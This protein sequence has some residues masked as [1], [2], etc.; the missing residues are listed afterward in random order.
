M[1]FPSLSWDR[2]RSGF[3]SYRK[4]IRLFAL[5]FLLGLSGYIYFLDV[6]IREA[7]EGRKFAV[8]ARVY[9]RALEVYP[10]L[11]LTSAQFADELRRDGYHENPEPNA[12]ATYKYTLNGLEFTTRDFVFGDGPQAHGGLR[13]AGH[14]A[15]GYYA[16]AG[17]GAAA[18]VA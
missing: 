10:G 17:G 12:P 14:A 11:K 13:D 7:F 5:L 9:G 4:V 18:G 16:R 1:K 6:T 15:K 8:P 2:F 3:N